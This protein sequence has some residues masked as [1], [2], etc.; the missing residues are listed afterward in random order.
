MG[1]RLS[2]PSREL[3]ARL[4]GE[5][6]FEERLRAANLTPMAGAREHSI[7][8]FR[9]AVNFLRIDEFEDLMAAGPRASIAYV[10]PD[11]LRRWVAEV[12]GDMELA[13]AIGKA[14]AEGSSYVETM[15]PVKALMEHRLSQ[16]EAVLTSK[17]TD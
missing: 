9:Q 10:D 4:L 12:F 11:A 15:R 16:C 1:V 7:Y 3:A 14:I 2:E 6:G 17:S 8:G 13:D 5:I